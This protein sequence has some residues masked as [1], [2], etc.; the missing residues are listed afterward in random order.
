MLSFASAAIVLLTVQGPLTVESPQVSRGPA[1]VNA[2]P[3][4]LPTSLPSE[5]VAARVREVL[6]D[7][8][9]SE[10]WEQL[11]DALPEMVRTGG[12]D[13]GSTFEAVRLADSISAVPLL[14][15]AR[16]AIPWLPSWSGAQFKGRPMI[17]T[18]L[19][20]VLVSVFNWIWKDRTVRQSLEDPAKSPNP[21]V[22]GRRDP[23]FVR[24]LAR[25]GR[26]VHEIARQTSMAQD[27][28]MI[29][30]ELQAEGT[31]Q[32]V[33]R[34]GERR[35]DEALTA[36]ERAAGRYGPPS[37]QAT[38]AGAVYTR[39]VRPPTGSRG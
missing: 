5:L 29:L 4:V 25:S 9:D 39:H 30:L 31:T 37:R 15:T 28:V 6:R 2:R 12:A 27:A 18:L 14:T 35:P 22:K 3:Y 20:L 10:A 36:R 24:T 8:R 11:A 26:P 21:G 19:A 13:P 23:W 32:R 33:S 1:E 38:A 17:A 16:D 34:D 7:H